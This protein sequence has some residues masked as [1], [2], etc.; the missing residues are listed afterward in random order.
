[1]A[2]RPDEETNPAASRRKLFCRPFS[3]RAGADK[4]SIQ[5][6][7]WAVEMALSRHFVPGY[8]RF[9]PP[10]QYVFSGIQILCPVGYGVIRAITVR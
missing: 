10:G 6:K 8:D 7:V 4:N 3:F 5:A 2:F 1:V 9:V